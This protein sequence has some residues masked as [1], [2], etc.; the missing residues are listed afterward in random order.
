MDTTNIQNE[1][2][3][4]HEGGFRILLSILGDNPAEIASNPTQY[5]QDFAAFLGQLA[6]GGADAIEVWNEANL[7]REWPSGLIGG[8][9]YTQMLAAAYQIIKANNPNTFVISAAP[10]PTGGLPNT[11]AAGYNDDTFLRAMAN[12]GAAQFMDCVGIHYNVGTVSPS[13]RT[14]APVDSNTH[15]SWYY[16]PMVEL[17][18]SIFPS[19]PLCFTEI[20]YPSGE[21]YPPL[22]AN[23]SWATGNTVA[24][25]ALWL[26]EAALMARNDRRIR[27]FIIWNVD[28]TVYLPDDPQAAYAIVRPDGT[29]PA[30]NTLD[31]QF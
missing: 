26:T 9:Q 27:L 12:A 15:Y 8:S 6:K 10:A 21:G 11:S 2:N 30:C 18:T 25:Q 3:V 17:Y 28:S 7:P 24:E 5:Y 20:G 1:I 16:L 23:F 29:C 22:P 19:R 31:V 14:G 4:A 13:A